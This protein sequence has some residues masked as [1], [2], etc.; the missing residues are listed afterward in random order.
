MIFA[1]RWDPCVAHFGL[2]A[3]NFVDS[4]FKDENVK[5]LL[6]AGAGFDPRSTIVASALAEAAP[7]T[8]ALLIKESR[9]DPGTDQTSQADNNT[10]G[11]RSAINDCK[12]IPIEIFGADNAVVGGRNVV[13][14]LS[15]ESF[16]DIT[17]VIVDVSALSV[18]TSFPIIRYFAERCYAGVGPTNLHVFVVHDP[19]LDT[20]IQSIASDNPGFVHG[21]KGELTL[22]DSVEKAKMWLPQLSPG[23]NGAL[24]R[25]HQFVEPDDTC[26]IVPFPATDPRI[27]DQLFGEY[28]SEIESAWFVDTRNI[29]FADESDPVDL[30]RTILKLD[31]LRKPVFEEYGGSHI[32]LSPLGSKVMALGALM[33]ALERDLP[34]AYLEAETFAL[35]PK[36]KGA[37][38]N[39][40]LIHVWLEGSAYPSDRPPFASLGRESS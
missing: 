24:S 39:P 1:T 7:D 40:H 37:C 19:A 23:R 14:S 20:D 11:L 36:A 33:A 30:Y 4:Y 2:D 3:E 5:G 35:G 9:P 21:F 28:R 32:V 18:G 29:V 31:D 10:L 6:V 22:Q 12:I 13:N 8:R 25:I 15:G 27:A 16:E 17:D 38:G 26:P 34:V